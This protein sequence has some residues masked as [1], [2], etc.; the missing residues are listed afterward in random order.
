[1]CTAMRLVHGPDETDAAG[2][3]LSLAQLVAQLET[4]ER[5]ELLN[6]LGGGLLDARWAVQAVTQPG[7]PEMPI[8]LVLAALARAIQELSRARELLAERAEEAA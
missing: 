2:K 8:V 6:T 5:I 3:R 7:S 1:M 4:G